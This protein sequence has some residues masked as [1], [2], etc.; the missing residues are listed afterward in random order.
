MQIGNIELGD[1]PLF[2]APMEDVTYKTFRYMCKQNGADVMYTEFV[3]SEALI[4]KV[5]KSIAKMELFDFD[6]PAAIQIY[7]HNT[8]SMVEA[9]KLAE[10]AK[11]D[12]IDINCG[13]PMKKIIRKGAGAGLL[14]E[15]DKMV[16]M[17]ARIVKAVRLPVTV[18]TR[19]GWDDNNKPIVELAE[20]LQDV[21]ITA[22]ALHGRTRAQLYSGTADWQ[23][24]GKVKQN[25]R[26]HI[27]LIGNGDI[28]SPQKAK[29]CLDIS[30]VD[31]LMIG[32]GSIGRPW[33]FKEVKHYLHTG[34]LLPAPLVSEIV[35]NVKSQLELTLGWR[36]SEYRAILMM[37]RH[38][39][40]YF[41]ALPNFRELRIRL[42]RAETSQEVF[43]ILDEISARYEGLQIDYSD[44]SLR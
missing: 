35:G 26:L 25:P 5:D 27:P 8:E 18:K 24:I 44:V 40:K 19:L 34:E 2:L 1:T 33:I 31:G 22:L 20:R 10:Q 32:R 42:L 11:P 4:R 9:A 38:F 12:F 28:N 16:E 7:G 13:C 3:A 39:A 15:P 21:G 17:V 23:L 36:D 29:E 37:R 41:P 30:G 43:Q 14:Q 6:R